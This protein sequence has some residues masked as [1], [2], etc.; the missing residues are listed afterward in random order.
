MEVQEFVRDVLLEIVKG[1]KEAQSEPGVGGYI[2]AG[3]NR[4][5]NSVRSDFGVSFSA[6]IV[7]TTVKFDMAVTAETSKQ[8]GRWCQGQNS[9]CGSGPGW[10]GGH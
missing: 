4:W 10:K 1:I 8:G 5:A 3:S 9:C 7:S 6:R 2:G